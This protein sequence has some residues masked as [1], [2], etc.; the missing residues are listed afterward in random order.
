MTATAAAALV[1][2]ASLVASGGLADAAATVTVAGRV[3]DAEGSPVPNLRVRI[4]G[5]RATTDAEGRF[6]TVA[7][8]GEPVLVQV[9]K[10]ERPSIEQLPAW[11]RVSW[12]H[13][14]FSTDTTLEVSLPPVVHQQIDVVDDRGNT[15]YSGA[16]RQCDAGVPER[17]GSGGSA[18][19]LGGGRV[20]QTGGGS[21]GASAWFFP[22]DD[23]RSLC[24]EGILQP[25]ETWGRTY[26]HGRVGSV[27]IDGGEPLAAS[28]PETEPVRGSVLDADGRPVPSVT[29]ET[30]HDHGPSYSSTDAAGSFRVMVPRGNNDFR[31]VRYQQGSDLPAFS[32]RQPNAGV[33]NRTR[34]R[35]TLPPS[36]ATDVGV[37][38]A[39]GS[40]ARKVNVQ[41]EPGPYPT[42]VPG[43]TFNGRPAYQL[44]QGGSGRTGRDGRVTL[45]AFVDAPL[46]EVSFQQPGDNGLS[47]WTLERRVTFDRPNLARASV[48]MPELAM[49]SG[50]TTFTREWGKRHNLFIHTTG[51]SV[52][53]RQWIAPGTPL[54]LP[55][56]VSGSQLVVTPGHIGSFLPETFTFTTNMDR[57]GPG[58]VD[59]GFR[60]PDLAHIRVRFVDRSGHPVEG[61]WL[62]SPSA[63]T[64]QRQRVFDGLGRS[65]IQ[66]TMQSTGSDVDGVAELTAFLDADVTR[67]E[68]HRSLDGAVVGVVRHAD[69]SEDGRLTVVV[70]TPENPVVQ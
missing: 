24:V 2:A 39:E 26:L 5:D 49:L 9:R 12:R 58:R 16:F 4:D 13:S 69:F 65:Q 3:V 40:P 54:R 44:T 19:G 52:E 53:G 70:G 45:R 64:S 27:V 57:V 14:I 41:T 11:F 21:G 55:V 1:A 28:L 31:A 67:L 50:P 47:W 7:S 32:L 56:S 6:T 59:S 37:L 30:E 34:W 17:S 18:T 43:G 29:I 36:I 60:L 8:A 42:F 48:T 35:V 38:T 20:S 10:G 22:D 23:Y 62:T 63:E 15:P 33:D 51:S 25:D 68:I 61:H 66:Q 46:G